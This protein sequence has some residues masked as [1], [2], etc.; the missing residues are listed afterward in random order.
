MFNIQY[1][2]NLIH[3]AKNFIRKFPRGFLLPE[4]FFFELSLAQ[5]LLH[6]IEATVKIQHIL[7]YLK[8]NSN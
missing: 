1:K 4:I 6:D 3:K 2:V 5:D 8:A 7:D